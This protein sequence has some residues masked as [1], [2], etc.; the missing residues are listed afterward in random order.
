VGKHRRIKYE[1]IIKY[2]KEIK[3]R[4]KQLSIEMMKSYQET[5]D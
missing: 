5:G 1:D 3:E 2:K 4:Q